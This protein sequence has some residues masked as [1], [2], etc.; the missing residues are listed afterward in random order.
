M[1]GGLRNDWNGWKFG[2][3]VLWK[4]FHMDR[5]MAE[6]WFFASSF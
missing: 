4:R 1:G 6:Q 2:M 5:R 3:V